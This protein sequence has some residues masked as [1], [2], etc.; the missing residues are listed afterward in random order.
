MSI[1]SWTDDPVADAESYQ[2]YLDEPQE[3]DIIC[4]N[5]GVNIT[6]YERDCYYKIEDSCYC[7]ECMDSWRI[8]V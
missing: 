2:N 4:D 1:P 5:C 3:D 6:K 8:Y 7:S